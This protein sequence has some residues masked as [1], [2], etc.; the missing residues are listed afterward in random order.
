[1]FVDRTVPRISKD[2]ERFGFVREMK[3]QIG[4]TIQRA[5]DAGH[6][7]GRVASATRSSAS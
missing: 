7:P 6:L 1:M 4:A 3:A 2:W 5:I